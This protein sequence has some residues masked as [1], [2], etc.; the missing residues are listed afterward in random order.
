MKTF[1]RTITLTAAQ[2]NALDTTPVA[3]IPA[4][5]AGLAI[6]P[7]SLIVAKTS[8]TAVGSCSNETIS[9]VYSGQTS[10]L[11]S[12]DAADAE[13]P[14]NANA[15]ISTGNSPS[16]YLSVVGKNQ[17]VSEVKPATGVSISAPGADVKQFNGTLQV[18]V[19]FNLVQIG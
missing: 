12:L 7:Q 9:L 19:L 10:P 15:V 18:T 2:V 6:V 17:A 1:A 16:T 8:G 4:P 3:V 14:A 11:L 13:T 5:K